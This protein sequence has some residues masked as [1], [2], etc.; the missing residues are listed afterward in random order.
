[1]QHSRCYLLFASLLLLLD[2]DIRLPARL[3]YIFLFVCTF[4]HRQICIATV[5]LPG[6]PV[7]IVN[8]FTG[9]WFQCQGRSRGCML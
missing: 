2:G 5:K 1:M 3:Q 7:P 9:A 4:V 6:H 8:I